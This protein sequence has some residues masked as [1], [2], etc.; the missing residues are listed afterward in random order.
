MPQTPTQI[1]SILHSENIRLRKSLGQNLLIDSNILR[2]IASYCD[3]RKEDIVFEIGTGMGS[4]TEFLAE[5]AGQVYSIELDERMIQVGK[6]QLRRFPNI[7]WIHADIL[8]LDFAPYLNMYRG[9]TLKIVGNLPYYITTPILMRFLE[10]K[11]PFERMVVTIQ[12]EVGERIVAV[13]GTK[14]YGI[15]SLMVQYRCKTKYLKT[16]TK[17]A[18]FPIPEVDSAVLR[19]TPHSIS[20]V[21]VGNETFFFAVIRAAFNQRRKTLLN[22]LNAIEKTTHLSKIELESI[23]K[24]LGIPLKIRGEELSLEDFARLAN[25]LFKSGN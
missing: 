14:N 12:K 17:R 22:A 7:K 25:H 19:L 3:L 16:I 15:L 24:E 18:F 9:K 23:F 1:K 2:L 10:E 5:K 6:S 13:P 20:T 11:F 4:L 8:K 21:K